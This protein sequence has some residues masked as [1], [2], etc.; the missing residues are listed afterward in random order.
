VPAPDPEH[1]LN[2]NQLIADKASEPEAWPEPFRR[3]PAE[4]PRLIE[5][6]P[7]HCV[8]ARAPPMTSTVRVI[9]RARA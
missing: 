6:A 1:R 4:P 3:D 2:F 9:D 8:D 7:G 5:I